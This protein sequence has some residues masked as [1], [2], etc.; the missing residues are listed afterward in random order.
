MIESKDISVIVQGAISKKETPKCLKSI[1]KYLP[2]A[3]ILLSTWE[4]SDVDGLDYDVLI[5]N[6]DPGAAFIGEINGI[7]MYNNI[8]RQLLSTQEGLKKAERKY[9]MK[10]RSDLILTGNKFL[11]YFDKFQKRTD[12]YKLF[13]RKILGSTI[14]TRYGIEH[15]KESRCDLTP[16]HISDWWFFGLKSDLDK[17]FMD[18]PL[19]DEPDFTNYFALEENKHKCSPYYFTKFKFAPEQYLGYEC[20]SRNFDDINMQDAS[21]INDEIMNKYRQCLVNNFIILEYKQ[22]GIYLNKYT[23]S[24][25]EKFLGEQYFGLYN[26]YRYENDY[27]EFC[28]N[29]YKI[30]TDDI[31]FKNPQYGIDFSRICK[32]LYMLSVPTLPLRV[33]L[34]QVFISIPVTT[35][36]FFIKHFKEIVKK[37]FGR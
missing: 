9:A 21:C 20:F 5:L 30:T 16:F 18:T 34:E 24:K 28:D 6:K 10:F 19:V 14:F 32:H 36:L 12:K 3:Q 13:E 8:N 26:T 29:E 15:I 7:R 17:Y 35:F 27:K 4:G 23:Y 22:S 25:R 31:C 11:E 37:Q 2:Q 33:R 1:R